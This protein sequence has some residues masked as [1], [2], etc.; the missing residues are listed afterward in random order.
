MNQPSQAIQD[1]KISGLLH[2]AADIQVVT[3][4]DVTR[5]LSAL[6]G[7]M[8]NV[9]QGVKENTTL[10]TGIAEGTAELLDLFKSVKGGFTVMGWIGQAAKWVASLLAVFAAIYAFVQNIRG[11]K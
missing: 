4:A 11:M 5:R 1:E 2:D 8:T 9:E 7:R 6:E 3:S 10:T